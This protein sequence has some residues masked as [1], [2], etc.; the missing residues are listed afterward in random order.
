MNGLK[1]QVVF[2]MKIEISKECYEML[3]AIAEYDDISIT[4]ELEDIIKQ[5]VLDLWKPNHFFNKY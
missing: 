4:E 1:W 5:A 3:V 2:K